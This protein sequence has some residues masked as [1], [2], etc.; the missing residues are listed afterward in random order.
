MKIVFVYDAVYP[1]E[2]GGAQK[3]IWELARRLADDHDVHLYGM[4]YW[5]GPETIEREGVTLH[6]VCEPKE[7]Y[8]DGR[9]S[10]P[11]ALYFAANVA[12]ALL[13]EDFD[14]IDCQEFPYFPCFVSKAHELLRDSTLVITW[15][16][17]WDDY[18]YD[19]LGKKGVF[20]KLVER[21]TLNLADTIIPISAYIESD[22][23]DLGRTHGLE[24][25][26]NGVDYD[27]L[28]SVP[29]ADAE[30]DII[31]VGRLS[32]HKNVDLLLDAVA[33]ASSQMDEDLS[34]CI[35]GDGPERE[36]LEAHATEAGVADQVEFLGFVEADDDVI[37]NIK[38]ASVFV[39]PSIREGFP[40]TIL[41]ANACG[42]P[43]I[44]VDHEENGS[45]AVV[46]DG[47]TGYIT[48]V[49]ADAIAHRLVDCLTDDVTLASLSA[50]AREFGQ[51]HDWDVIVDELEEVYSSAVQADQ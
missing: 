13:K 17:V 41:E 26:E 11:Q 18:W 6:G 16:E 8:V 51:Q 25:V 30:W 39:L 5:D 50:G 37:A 36:S 14:L 9:R 15:Y 12:P 44:V 40:N 31:Y 20:G 33:D 47:V 46:D 21:A 34:C 7:L 19:Y 27:G 28:Q 38:A 2:K 32:E 42:V 1:H 10:I 29:E 24:V 4:H 49:S 22:L 23:R 48:E 35:I 45:T 3:R 43:S